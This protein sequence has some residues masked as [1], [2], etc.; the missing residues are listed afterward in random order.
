MTARE[1]GTY[2]DHAKL[3]TRPTLT[4]CHNGAVRFF[5]EF[6]AVATQ[7]AMLLTPVRPRQHMQTNTRHIHTHTLSLFPSM[8][9]THHQCRLRPAFR[10]PDGYTWVHA[11]EALA[12]VRHQ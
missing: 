12:I 7:I 10:G 4:Q 1:R 3:T 9:M 2:T 6:T 8:H 11:S 5:S